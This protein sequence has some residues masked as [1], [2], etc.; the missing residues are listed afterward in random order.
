M[1][2]SK[3]T[4]SHQSKSLDNNCIPSPPHGR[5]SMSHSAA[6]FYMVTER[7][8]SLKKTCY[9]L[10]Y[11]LGGIFVPLLLPLCKNKI[12]QNATKNSNKANSQLSSIPFMYSN[13][14]ALD[15]PRVQEVIQEHILFLV[16]IS[17]KQRFYKCCGDCFRRVI[18][19]N[20]LKKFGQLI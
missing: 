3:V 2:H 13:L 6:V 10:L 17:K 18:E 8:Y 14:Q 9:F 1:F 7:N 16:V 19:Y 5:K 12:I 20:F 11:Y 4:P 15:D